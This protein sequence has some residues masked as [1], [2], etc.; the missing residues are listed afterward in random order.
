MNSGKELKDLIRLCR[1]GNSAAQEK[2][3]K[4]FYGSMMNICLRYTKDPDDAVEVLNTGY[5]K[6]FQNIHK[7]NGNGEFF[8]GWIHKIMVN[9]ALDR[10]RFEKNHN[11]NTVP[12]NTNIDSRH[13]ENEALGLF[14]EKDLIKMIESLPPTSRAVFNLYVFEN[15]THKEIG[16]ILNMT[17]STSQWHLLNARKILISKITNLKLKESLING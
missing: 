1:E 13:I 10:I 5:L 11:Q 12:L 4:M 15:Y 16:E 3:Y 2:L 6:I 14:E 7:Y 8:H 9:S 17:D